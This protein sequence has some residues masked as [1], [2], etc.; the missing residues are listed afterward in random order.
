M[1]NFIARLGVQVDSSQNDVQNQINKKIKDARVKAAIELHMNNEQL[2]KEIN[3]VKNQIKTDLNIDIND[4][5]ALQ[6]IKNVRKEYE[7]L[8]NQ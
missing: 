2:R 7:G 5:T 1:D 3:I 4:K 6:S 8:K